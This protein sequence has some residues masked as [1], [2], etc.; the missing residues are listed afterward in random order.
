[1]HTMTIAIAKDTFSTCS[2]FIF[3]ILFLMIHAALKQ[4]KIFGGRITAVLSFCVTSLSMIAMGLMF[5]SPQTSGGLPVTKEPQGMPVILIPYAT[6]GVFLLLMFLL[7]SLGKLFNRS[8]T[9]K[10]TEE[11]SPTRP[12]L[13]SEQKMEPFLPINLAAHFNRKSRPQSH[14]RI[15]HLGQTLRSVNPIDRIEHDMKPCDADGGRREYK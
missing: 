13:P 1:M 12:A 11:V 5:V 4:S 9:S 2:V 15:D 6:L 14:T 10:D 8:N 3:V 7:M